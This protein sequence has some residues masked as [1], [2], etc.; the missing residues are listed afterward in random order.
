M[1]FKERMTQ[2]LELQ[3]A[4]QVKRN[5]YLLDYINIKNNYTPITLEELLTVWGVHRYFDHMIEHLSTLA[6]N[7][8]TTSVLVQY[9]LGSLN[10]D[11]DEQKML[12]FAIVADDDSL[13]MNG[14]VL[15]QYGKI[16]FHT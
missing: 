4:E 3:Q 1:N 14:G 7:K 9:D 13:G 2:L 15:F 12:Y 8:E 11:H 5:I 6:P 16:S 10:V